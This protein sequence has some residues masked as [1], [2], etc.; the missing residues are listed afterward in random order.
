M[1]VTNFRTRAKT[2]FNHAPPLAA[3]LLD[4]RFNYSL[5]EEQVA[6]GVRYLTFIHRKLTAR[7]EDVKK[8]DSQES[9]YV[10]LIENEGNPVTAGPANIDCENTWEKE[11]EASLRE[12]NPS[13]QTP[14]I[15]SETFTEA[16]M[17]A[18]ITNFIRSTPKMSIRDS[19]LNFWAKEEHAHRHTVLCSLAKLILAIPGTQVTV[20]RLFSQK[21][22]LSDL[23]MKMGAETLF[24][25]MLIRANPK[26]I[27]K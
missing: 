13:F 25:V 22:V 18:L 12:K 10:N 20:E 23:R 7:R 14:T 24:N 19:I 1:L 6:I 16:D 26:I 2:V 4:P 27:F 5:D 3:L 17:D 11:F 8:S 15:N 9:S 21:F